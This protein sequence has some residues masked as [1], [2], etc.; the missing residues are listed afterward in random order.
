MSLLLPYG[1]V[2]IELLEDDALI[3]DLTQKYK[4]IAKVIAVPPSENGYVPFPNVGDVVFFDEYSYRTFE[5]NKETYHF[6][7]TKNKG[8][9]GVIRTYE[10]LPPRIYKYDGA[11]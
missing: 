5:F 9:W 6:L 4:K 10:E 8:I 1:V 11:K 3:P 2:R 7:D